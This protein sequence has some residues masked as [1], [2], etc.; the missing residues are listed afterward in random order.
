MKTKKQFSMTT[1]AIV[2]IGGHATVPP[3]IIVKGKIIFSP[4]TA[5]APFTRYL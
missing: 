2:A 1:L 5:P 3:M 4:L